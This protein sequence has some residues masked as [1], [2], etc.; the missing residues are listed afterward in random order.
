MKIF[1]NINLHAQKEEGE[2]G[3]GELSLAKKKSYRQRG[4]GG[5]NAATDENNF[6]SLYLNV[7]KVNF[8]GGHEYATEI[9]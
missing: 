4:T 9:K 3:E 2:R 1:R 6:S 7:S 8:R 5:D